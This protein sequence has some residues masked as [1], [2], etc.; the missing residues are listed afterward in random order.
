MS[1]NGRPFIIVGVIPGTFRGVDMP[2]VLPT[3]FWVP[4]SN[5]AAVGLDL[6]RF[7]TDNGTLHAKGRLRPGR[8]ATDAAVSSR[9]WPAS[10]IWL[11]R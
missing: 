7:D 8:T 1:I 11:N 5:A 10:S 3:P 9:N 6:T 2:N 4:L